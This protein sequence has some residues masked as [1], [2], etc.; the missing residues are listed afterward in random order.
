MAR[1]RTEDQNIV[2]PQCRPNVGT[3]H[4]LPHVTIC[5]CKHQMNNWNAQPQPGAE[6]KGNGEVV[7]VLN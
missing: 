6:S 5:K 3:E 7:P 2:L 1:H 4:C